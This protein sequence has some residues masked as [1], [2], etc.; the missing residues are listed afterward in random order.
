MMT[1][2]RDGPKVLVWDIETD[3]VAADRVL[4]IGWK[5]AGRGKKAGLL[6]YDQFPSRDPWWSDKPMLE[7]FEEVWMQ[8]D[9]HVGWFQTGFDLPTVN[10]RRIM[11]KLGPMAH[12]AA[13]DLWSEARAIFGRRYGNRLKHW[14]DRLGFESAHKTEV[15]PSVWIAARHGDEKALEYIYDHCRADI[16][17]TEAAYWEFKPW[18]R[19]PVWKQG[20]LCPSC[21]SGHIQARGVQRSITRV[22]QRW[23]CAECGKWFRAARASVSMK[24]RG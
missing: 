13:V 19:E 15:K 17:V 4:C 5:W 1:T 21:G 18:L 6:T 11:N 3:G 16:L 7:A 23:Q 2:K 8:A 24:V 10:R 22:Y 12:V 14:E 20:L 9:W